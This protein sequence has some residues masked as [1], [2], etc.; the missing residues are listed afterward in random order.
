VTDLPNWLLGDPVLRAE[1]D[2]LG[3]LMVATAGVPGRLT[4]DEIDG[5]LGVEDARVVV[6]L[7]PRSRARSS[8]LS[9]S[10]RAQALRVMARRMGR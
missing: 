9:H 7:R 3:E 8:A 4:N 5:A 2:L 6:P 10:A 1:I